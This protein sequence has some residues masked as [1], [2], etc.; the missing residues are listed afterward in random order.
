[1]SVCFGM[2]PGKGTR[3]IK[4]Y[5]LAPVGVKPS[6]FTDVVA[7]HL[8]QMEKRKFIFVGPSIEQQ[9]NITSTT[10]SSPLSSSSISFLQDREMTLKSVAS[11]D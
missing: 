4:K 7:R 9:T 8:T 10:V 11:T 5:L 6:K 2:G 3:G 1:M